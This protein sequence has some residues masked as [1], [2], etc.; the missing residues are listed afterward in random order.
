MGGNGGSLFISPQSPLPFS[1]FVTLEK[2][3]KLGLVNFCR[4]LW[5]CF[6][7]RCIRTCYS[8]PRQRTRY[9]LSYQ[10]LRLFVTQA[11]TVTGGR[12]KKK[13][14][15]QL[16]DASLLTIPAEVFVE[17]SFFPSFLFTSSVFWVVLTRTDS[18][19]LSILSIALTSPVSCPKETEKPKNVNNNNKKFCQ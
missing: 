15:Q 6:S 3:R 17:I 19:I 5:D 11:R 8:R 7:L 2:R 4:D 12:K 9:I 10:G 13:N 18:S 14:G 1:P 16:T